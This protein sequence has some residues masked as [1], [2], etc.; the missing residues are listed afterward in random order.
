MDLYTATLLFGAL[1]FLGGAGFFFGRFEAPAMR[2]LRSPSAA[3]VLGA[4]A[5]AWF[6]WI[7]FNLGEADFGQYRFLLMALFGGAGLLSFKYLPD[8]LGVRALCVL[9]ILT[10]RQCLDAAFMAEPASRLVMVSLV[11]VF[12]VA[13]VY[14]GCLPYRLRD[15]FNWLFGRPVRARLFAVLMCSCGAAVWISTLFY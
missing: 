10:F 13:C 9:L 11:Y 7:L 2:F 15:F 12:T 14:F 6:M 3:Y 5:I 4:A 1:C 8:F